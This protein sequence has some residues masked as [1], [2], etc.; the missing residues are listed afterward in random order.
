LEETD[1]VITIE[2]QTEV[3]TD[4]ICLRLFVKSV[5]RIVKFLF[6][7]MEVDRFIVVLVLRLE[8]E[9]TPIDQQEDMIAQ[10]TTT[11]EEI[12]VA[13]VIPELPS[14]RIIAMNFWL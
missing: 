7:P 14:N 13:T 1:P 9:E 5:V 6:D 3:V 11:H 4:Q 10:Q 12:L 2:A 8:A